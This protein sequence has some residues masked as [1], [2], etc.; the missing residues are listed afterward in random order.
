MRDRISQRDQSSEADT[1][2]KN[3]PLAE[4]V[5]EGAYRRDL[6]VLV[7]E[8]LGLSDSPCSGMSKVRTRKFLAISASR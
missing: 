6:V 1:G 5:D 8:R 2:E 4:Q 7:D 3:R